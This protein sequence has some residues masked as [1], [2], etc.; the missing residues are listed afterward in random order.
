MDKP[1]S[2]SENAGVHFNPPPFEPTLI[3]PEMAV[4]T[5][6]TNYWFGC[7]CC[8]A[9]NFSVQRLEPGPGLAL[10]LFNWNWNA[11]MVICAQRGGEIP[12]EDHNLDSEETLTVFEDRDYCGMGNC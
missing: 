6:A 3:P 4:E 9:R 1:W 8:W 2:S 7:P 10:D 12:L 11:A 5:V